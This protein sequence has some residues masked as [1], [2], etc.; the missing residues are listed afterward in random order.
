MA[1]SL[2]MS[3]PPAHRVPPT[4]PLPNFE[5]PSAFAEPSPPSSMSYPPTTSSYVAQFSAS[6]RGEMAT[7]THLY[8]RH[9]QYRGQ[10]PS[11]PVQYGPIRPASRLTLEHAVENVQAHLAALT[12]RLETLETLTNVSQSHVSHTPRG[13][14]SPGRRG[15][16]SDGRNPYWDIDD[17]GLWSFVLNP[18]SRG[19]DVLRDLSTFFARNENRSPTSIIVRRLCL[20][21]SFL[22]C[23]FA[24]VRAL[25]RK[26]GVRR[27][28]VRAALVMLWQ[29]IL[30][31]KPRMMIDQGV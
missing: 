11:H 1:A 21:V 26:S 20:D 18:L 25:W 24:V 31:T 13:I 9:H 10:S 23:V 6:S 8:P 29:A 17:L 19:L 27:R 7:P 14:G 22:V 2:A 12:E 4:Q 15:S 5:T 28:E 3:P 16:P 30:G